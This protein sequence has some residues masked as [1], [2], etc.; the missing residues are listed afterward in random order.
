[1]EIRIQKYIADAGIASRRRVEAMI[2]EGL[3]KVNGKVLK[4]QGIKINPIHDIVEVNGKRIE[5]NKTLKY[6]LL[7]KPVRY[8]STASDEK[9]RSTVIDLV[10]KNVRVYPVGRLDYMSS[11]LLLLTNDGDLTYRLTHPKHDIAKKYI[12]V[13]NPK[14]SDKDILILSNGVDLKQYK[15]SPCSIRLLKQ[16]KEKQIY[17][18]ILHEGKNR[19]IRR[20]FEYIGTKVLSLKRV[21]IGNLELNNLKP[22]EYRELTPEE[23]QYLKQL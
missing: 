3:I 5:V 7:H 23:I 9:G 17:E 12:A 11:G 22:G 16:D 20:M 2:D 6:Y 10:P 1:M 14:V 13:I 19:Q 21:A 15:T 18:I 4:T 8:V